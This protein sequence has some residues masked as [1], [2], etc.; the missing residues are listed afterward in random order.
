MKLICLWKLN[1]ILSCKMNT[2][3]HHQLVRLKQRPTKSQLRRRCWTEICHKVDGKTKET[4]L[5]DSYT[6]S[7]FQL[8]F[9]QSEQSAGER[10]LYLGEQRMVEGNKD[11]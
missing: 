1:F 6:S 11:T 3:R 9:L 7:C 5:R 4:T 2:I 10:L 8:F